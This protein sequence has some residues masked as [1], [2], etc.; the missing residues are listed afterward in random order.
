MKKGVFGGIGT[1]ANHIRGRLG[2][3]SIILL[4]HRVA[5]A[6]TDPYMLCVSPRHFEEH[7]R[8]INRLG[9]PTHLD[10]LAAAVREGHVPHGR[11]CVTFDDGYADNFI[12]A[13]PLLEKYGVPATVFMTTGSSGRTR[14]FWWDELERIFLG[15]GRLPQRLD[16]RIN[17]TAQSWRLGDAA[18]LGTNDLQK[19]RKWNLLDESS[20]TARH[21]V[22]RSVYDLL[23]PMPIAQ[24][25]DMLDE[26]LTWAGEESIVR[27]THRAL[28]L[29]ELPALVEGDTVRVGGHTVNHPALNSQPIEVQRQ[30]IT[31]CKVMLEDAL[32]Q[33]LH[34]FAY[35][36]GYFSDATVTEVQSAGFSQ[37]CACFSRPVRTDSH[38][39]M[40]PRIDVGNWSGDE[41]ERRLNRHI[42][43]W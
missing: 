4:Y 35:P 31:V 20:P 36:Y 2:S 33:P 10:D 12:A 21:E 5:D 16:L 29:E 18:A 28:K 30:E 15:P 23:Q 42:R 37:A 38:P 7:M 22:F 19:H 26:L 13:K 3:K 1:L 17:G 14:E 32:Q 11:V 43:G 24:R 40:L 9:R 25:T 27:N 8:V 41:F 34:S 39:F 6:A